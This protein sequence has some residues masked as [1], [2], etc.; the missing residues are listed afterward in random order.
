MT[1]RPRKA[2]S[3]DLKAHSRAIRYR[4][5]ALAET[6]PQKAQLLQRIADDAERRVLII[7]DWMTPR[8]YE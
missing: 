3:R 7:P 8:I 2:H 4:R 5:L 6:D 1:F